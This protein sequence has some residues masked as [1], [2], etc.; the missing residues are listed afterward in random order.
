[1]QSNHSILLVEDEKDLNR[2]LS[3][4]LK[5]YFKKAIK[6]LKGLTP[7]QQSK[8]HSIVRRIHF[9]RGDR[10]VN[11]FHKYLLYDQSIDHHR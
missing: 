8:F 6:L 2:L 11:I 5:N 10:F 7:V 4:F 9:V 1:M 3:E